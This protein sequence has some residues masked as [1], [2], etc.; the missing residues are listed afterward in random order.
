MSINSLNSVSKGLSGLVSGMDT[1]SMVDAL[2]AGTQSKIDTQK[3]NKTTL[4]NKQTIYRDVY[5][6]LKNFRDSFLTVSGSNSMLLSSFYNTMLTESS[7]TAFKASATGSAVAGK[8]TINSIQQLAQNL[9]LKANNAASGTVTGK[10]DLGKMVEGTLIFSMDGVRKEISM[11][12]DAKDGAD[13]A[14]QLQASITKTFGKGISVKEDNGT[15]TF[16]ADDISREF[17]I[18]GKQEVMDVLGMKTGISN[19]INKG[20]NLENVNFAEKLA[21]NSFKFTI[22]DVD[23]EFSSN[24][25]LNKVINDINNSDA[26]VKIN[27]STLEDK[28]SIESTVSGEGTTIEMSQSEG[29]L[30]SAMFGIGSGGGISGKN[31]TRQ[32]SIEGGY[33]GDDT[34]AEAVQAYVDTVNGEIDRI[35]KANG[36]F[37]L[38]VNGANVDITLPARAEGDDSPYTIADLQAA[39]GAN[40]TLKDAGVTLDFDSATGKMSL[41]ANQGVELAVDEGFAAAGFTKGAKNVKSATADT[42]LAQAGMADASIKIGNTT[43]SLSGSSTMEETAAAIK[44]ALVNEVASAGGDTSKIEV[45]FDYSEDDNKAQFRIFG[46]DIP[47][48]MELGG[49]AEKMFGTDKVEF[50]KT[51]PGIT[52]VQ[53]GQNAVLYVNDQRVVR[54]SNEFNLDGINYE[55]KKT[56]NETYDPADYAA[57]DVKPE[58]AEINVTRDTDKIFEG[59]SKF[60]EE[61]NKVIDKVWGIVKEEAVY[62]DY[63]P[64][65]DAQK[66]E[67][68]EKEIS[69]WEEKSKQ[70]LLRGDTVLQ[71]I[72]DEMR[73][74]LISRPAGSKYSLADMGISLVYDMEKGYGGKMVFNDDG[75]SGDGTKLKE[76]IAQD[77][78]ALQALF[79]NSDTGILTRTNNLLDQATKGTTYG[80]GYEYAHL[81]LVNLAGKPGGFDTSS[82]IYKELKDI[83]ENLDNLAIKYKLEY[84]RYWSQFNSMEAMISN[85]NQQSS[86]LTQQFSS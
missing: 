33:T 23:F 40:D 31:L 60:M 2:L 56:F 1:Q 5:S 72:M 21:G 50:N 77:P 59:V 85:M 43:L 14:S 41:S 10:L 71:G 16:E 22:N 53:K 65:T 30:L 73:N 81:S 42:T 57:G 20:M 17:T 68:T 39:I 61:Y 47:M 28:F 84:N 66:D 54:N 78:E 15:I 75:T 48:S 8:T 6:T 64:L 70:G 44:A 7:S 83:D 4:Q 46:V 11:P 67:M 13:F 51:G 45:N 52:E 32:I 49:G 79:T 58:F 36:K 63:A 34:G 25:S 69:A 82:K 29:N 18:M 19:K 27:Y 12:T 74:I 9:K 24:T 37:T 62:K 76:M 80:S 3:G 86:W 55:I 26:G 38:N 35:A